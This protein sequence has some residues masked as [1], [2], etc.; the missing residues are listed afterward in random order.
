[1]V[2]LL[3]AEKMSQESAA[4]HPQNDGGGMS[5]RLVRLYVPANVDKRYRGH[6]AQNPCRVFISGQKRSDFGV[7][8]RELRRRSAIL[9]AI[10]HVRLSGKL[11]RATN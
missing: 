11:N 7:I 5:K 6:D 4:L 8:K 9:S 3:N 2:C 10:A 1:M